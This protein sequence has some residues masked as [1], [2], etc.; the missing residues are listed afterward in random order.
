LRWS[1]KK[2]TVESVLNLDILDLKK[3]G[4]LD[5]AASVPSQIQWTSNGKHSSSAGYLLQKR[6]GLRVAMRLRYA[7]A[8]GDP[9]GY[10]YWVSIT[11]TSCHYG[12]VRFW[13]I[14]PGSKDDI[15]CLRRCRK[16][17]TSAG[18]IF[19]C[20]Q[21]QELT[22]ES[23]QKSGSEF[24]EFIERPMKIHDKALAALER[25][26]R[27]RKQ[28]RTLQRKDRAEQALQIGFSRVP[29]AAEILGPILD[30]KITR[31][32]WRRRGRP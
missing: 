31:D 13:F 22:Y 17:F 26:R 32:S 20:R 28:N 29:A 10:D 5:L 9:R 6:D 30:W 7:T 25:S 19:A 15:S 2:D 18:P 27:S 3:K 12:G 11:S 24:Y 16:L 8:N 21:C 1:R 14:C 23:T 4:F